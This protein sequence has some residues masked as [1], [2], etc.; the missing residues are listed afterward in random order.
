MD[1]NTA[2]VQTMA[3]LVGLE[4]AY[5]LYLWRPYLSW[6]EVEH[7]P[8][9][10]ATRCHALRAAGAEVK[11]PGDPRTRRDQLNLPW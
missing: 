11:L 6:D 10:D 9:F 2:N 5:D 4:G 3:K 7:V 1:L 8:G